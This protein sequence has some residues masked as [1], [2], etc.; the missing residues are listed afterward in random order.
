MISQKVVLIFSANC[1]QVPERTKKKQSLLSLDSSYFS[2]FALSRRL[3]N[4]ELTSEQCGGV[5]EKV[6]K[7]RAQ[8]KSLRELNDIVRVVQELFFTS[9]SFKFFLHFINM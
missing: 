5:M 9:R 4:H 7:S 6:T 3:K 2:L 8:I 1:L